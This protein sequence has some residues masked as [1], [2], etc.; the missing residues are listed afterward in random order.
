M[1]KDQ[2]FHNL[3]ELD[4]HLL[5]QY[6]AMD[7]K[8]ARKHSSKK[9]AWCLVAIAAC[10]AILVCAL[11]PV[12]M[13]AHPAG[14]AV[15]SGDSEAL[16]EQ[17]NK[18]EGFAAWQEMTAEK[19]EQSLPEGLYELLQ[20]TPIM[21]VLTQSQYPDYAMKNA[22]F[23]PYSAAKQAELLVYYLDDPNGYFT[24]QNM[25][26]V[27]TEQY[28][29][30]AAPEKFV[31]DHEDARYELRYMYSETQG[32]DRQAVHVYELYT[33]QGV[34]TAYLDA[35]T[36]ECIY[37]ST[38]TQE[39]KVAD[40]STPD[41][42]LTERAYQ[43]LAEKVRDPEAYELFTYVKNGLLIVEYN[44]EF[45]TT[46]TPS[47]T[48]QEIGLSVRGCD[49]AI[50]AFDA[51]GNMVSFDLCYLGALRYAEKAFPGKLYTMAEEYFRSTFRG[52]ASQNV[53]DVH[54][55]AYVVVILRDGS[56]ALKHA[57]SLDLVDGTTVSMG[58]LV[59]LTA[60]DPELADQ[61]PAV[62]QIQDQM[63]V[64]FM[65]T[66]YY[67]TNKQTTVDMY[68][69]DANGNV[70]CEVM[71]V[72]GVEQ[73]RITY[74]YDE[75]GRMIESKTVSEIAPAAGGSVT[76][77]YD[78]QGRVIQRDHF[79]Y[80]GKPDDQ[81]FLEYDTQGRVIKEEGSKT[82]YRYIYSEN[83]SY[84]LWG[85][86]KTGS[87]TSKAEYLYD[88]AGNCTAVRNYEGDEISSEI[89]YEYNDRNQKISKSTF[90]NGELAQN[91]V[92]EYRDGKEVRTLVYRNGELVGI[93]TP[94]YNQFGECIGREDVD[95]NGK[96][97]QSYEYEYGYIGQ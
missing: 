33:N 55:T 10:M 27:S 70:I 2:F 63:R 92:M 41:S 83:N 84:V 52:E 94:R 77:T 56:L 97:V 64:M 61:T 71:L 1:K 45:V 23:A 90:V 21:D 75:Q 69:Y 35:Q 38:P 86:S 31:L 6:F 30:D 12:G 82:V 59:P 51:V 34:F 50:F 39:G 72:D 20:T 46:Y 36:G 66:I 42:T 95:A 53:V 54:D 68:E 7:K 37:W 62:E 74:T 26:D 8:L 48:D 32:L 15:L 89:V 14:R 85:E 96:L 5:E 81:V 76:Y 18:I 49:R 9:R 43:M 44:R 28:E 78:A 16:T 19:L 79:D 88:A 40:G 91:S 47:G 11:V 65:E 93:S 25:I 13:L 29:D 58:Y 4:D 73:M 22:T 87:Y 57:F 67:A 24:V 17:L 80:R 3:T 60:A